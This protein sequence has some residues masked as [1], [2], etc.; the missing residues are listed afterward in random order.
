MGIKYGKLPA[1]SIL[2]KVSRKLL[3]SKGVLI[4]ARPI[5]GQKRRAADVAPL[6]SLGNPISESKKVFHDKK[7]RLT[8]VSLVVKGFWDTD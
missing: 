7:G 1:S 5:I 8:K 4:G 2:H 6:V 3:A